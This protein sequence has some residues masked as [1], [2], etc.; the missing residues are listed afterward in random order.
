MGEPEDTDVGRTAA[1]STG[2]AAHII[3]SIILA[4]VFTAAV[5]LIAGYAL[6]W[7]VEPFLVTK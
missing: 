7:L 2:I 6:D 3:R 4:A 5:W 1:S